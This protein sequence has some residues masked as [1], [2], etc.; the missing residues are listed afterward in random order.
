M[1]STPEK[2]MAAQATDKRSRIVDTA[3]RLVHEQGFARTSLAD[4]ARES[5]VPLGNLYYYFKTKDAIGEALIE[6]M[7]T[8]HGARRARW[9]AELE[10]R[11]RI[12][13]FV[14]AT[15]DN[16]ETLARRGC[17]FG[18]LCAE[19]HKEP[20]PLAERAA[21][22]FDGILKWLEAQFRLLGKGAESRDLAFHLVSALQGASLLTNTFHDTRKI[23]R[24]CNRLKEWV[25]SL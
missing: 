1:G 16:R 17:S 20:G 14:Q 25:R 8:A 2:S 21:T 5:G 11:E 24:E 19:L 6:K 13:A 9:D 12:E 23:T 7:S 4:I 15:I 10:P 3:A 22:L 18:T